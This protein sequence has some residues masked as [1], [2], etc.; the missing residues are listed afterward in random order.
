MLRRLAIGEDA[1]DEHP[2][3]TLWRVS[4]PH[5]A[6]AETLVSGPLLE[7][8]F[9]QGGGNWRGD[10]GGDHRRQ[11]QGRREWSWPR[12]YQLNLRT[13]KVAHGYQKSSNDFD[14]IFF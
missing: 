13:K 9:V 2:D 10:G 8:H 12:D 6:E 1:F 14:L 3:V 4:A 11:A 5:D 7:A